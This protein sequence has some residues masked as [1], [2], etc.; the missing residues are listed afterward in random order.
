K[1][2]L[3][4]LFLPGSNSGAAFTVLAV[5]LFLA[6]LRRLRA[7]PERIRSRRLGGVAARASARVGLPDGVLLDALHVDVRPLPVGAAARP[8]DAAPDDPD[9]LVPLPRALPPRPLGD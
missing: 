4:G 6:C 3:A 2:R 5:G 8:P 1:N 9:P 7:V